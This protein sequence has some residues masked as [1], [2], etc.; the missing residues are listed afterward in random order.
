VSPRAL[1]TEHGPPLSRYTNSQITM[2]NTSIG[3]TD[4][5]YWRRSKRQWHCF[6]KLLNEK[7]FIS[8]CHQAEI[9]VVSGQNI[10]RPAVW[11]RCGICDGLE[12]ARRGWDNSGQVSPRRAS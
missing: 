7:G 5:L 4:K 6:K 10:S 12:M 1:A 8:L 11:E 3:F 2:G 9:L